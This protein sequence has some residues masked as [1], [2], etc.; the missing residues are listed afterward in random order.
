MNVFQKEKICPPAI[1]R[2]HNSARENGGTRV[3]RQA[4][5]RQE[6]QRLRRSIRL[7]LSFASIAERAAWLPAPVRFVMLFILRATAGAGRR[8]V[9]G[10]ADEFGLDLVLPRIDPGADSIDELFHLARTFRILGSLLFDLATWAGYF[11]RRS[12]LGENIFCAVAPG[13]EPASALHAAS[14]RRVRHAHSIRAGPWRHGPPLP[15]RE[16]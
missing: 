2:H 10:M 3:D 15:Y 12:D 5:I 4:A 9:A 1:F 11:S 14:H 13:R 16:H 7:L 6:E 8:I